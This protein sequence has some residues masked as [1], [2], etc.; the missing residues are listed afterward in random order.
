MPGDK[1][2]DILLIR[3]HIDCIFFVPFLLDEEIVAGDEGI[4]HIAHVAEEGELVFEGIYCD[5]EIGV[6]GFEG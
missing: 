6:A 5:F 2:I 4:G 3:R 1:L